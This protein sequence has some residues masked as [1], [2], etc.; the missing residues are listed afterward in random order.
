MTFRARPSYHFCRRMLPWSL[1]LL[2]ALL[3]TRAALGAPAPQCLWTPPWLPKPSAPGTASI[4]YLQLS[5]SQIMD[6]QTA[7]LIAQSLAPDRTL[8]FQDQKDW[9]DDHVFPKRA[10]MAA[11]I[12]GSPR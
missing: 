7:A 1:A 12:S 6:D 9:P 3:V 5:G 2:L 8:H 11:S 4:Q 10:S